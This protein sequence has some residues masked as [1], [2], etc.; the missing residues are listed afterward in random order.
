MLCTQGI[1]GL[2][3]DLDVLADDYFIRFKVNFETDE[4]KKIFM[5]QSKSSI[6]EWLEIM[7]DDDNYY[8]PRKRIHL[9]DVDH[10]IRTIKNIMESFLHKTTSEI[11]AMAQSIHHDF[12]TVIIIPLDDYT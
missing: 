8:P 10:C 5:E 7:D 6:Y 4:I 1:M 9:E 11:Y 3:M 12:L 2:A